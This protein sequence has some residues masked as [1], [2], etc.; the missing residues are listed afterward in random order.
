MASSSTNTFNPDVLKLRLLTFQDPNIIINNE[1]V[2]RS[3]DGFISM[4]SDND[5]IS[6]FL[7]KVNVVDAYS[8][9]AAS[10][11]DVAGYY[12]TITMTMLPSTSALPSS[13][14]FIIGNNGTLQEDIYG[15]I[16]G[17]ITNLINEEY[18]FIVRASLSMY[19]SSTNELVRTDNT[20]MYCYFTSNRGD[21][22]YHWD[23][24]WLSGLLYQPLS[25]ST[26][27]AYSL[28][29]FDRGE[30]VSFTM[31]L[32]NRPSDL[33]MEIVPITSGFVFDD[34]GLKLQTDGSVLGIVTISF[35]PGTYYFKVKGYRTSDST[36]VG[37]PELESTIFSITFT[38]TIV[39]DI[40]Q[41]GFI[42]W[43]TDS[44]LGTQYENYPSFFG[45]SASNP[46][47][48]T[49]VYTV[50]Q[51]SSMQLPSSMVL[52]SSSGLIT[53][54]CPYVNISTLYTITIRA[55]V[56]LSYSEKTFTFTVKPIYYT[57]RVF[58]LELPVT[59]EIRKRIAVISW[60]TKVIDPSYVYRL[61]DENFGRKRNQN[62]YFISGLVDDN[63]FMGYWKNNL[64]STDPSYGVG[65]DAPSDGDYT[66]YSSCFLD[67]LM[68]YHH[69]YD[70]EIN[71]I[72]S[73]P[74]YDPNGNHICDVVYYTI[75]DNRNGIGGFDSNNN[76]QLL[77]DPNKRNNA[78]PEWNMT[79]TDTRIFPASIGNCRLDLI[80]TTNR[81]NS[82]TYMVR[83][84]ATSGIGLAKSEGL[85]M[86]M[87]NSKQTSKNIGFTAAIEICYCSA[88]Y[89]S[90]VVSSINSG[91]QYN[92][93]GEK[94][95]IDRYIVYR[96][97]TDKMH[98]DLNS[99]TG[100]ETTFDSS[101]NSD[102][103]IDKDTGTWFDVT[104]TEYST[105]V[106][107]PPG[108]IG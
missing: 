14:S 63:N 32:D 80:M 21:T 78:I 33:V 61:D 45:V 54:K 11:T 66:N 31:V 65:V 52:N 29:T 53:G 40:G 79:D 107:F 20:D 8:G 2:Q 106:K 59:E 74:V 83:P 46:N 5:I 68:N 98:F 48:D 42:T 88:N 77:I 100:A 67:K 44:N 69:P 97:L 7:F 17:S 1:A 91:A 22:D 70:V 26:S 28:G 6:N 72:S 90:V 35:T 101:V 27:V 3:S 99:T 58:R 103:S 82:P 84:N 15:N 57:D 39:S 18:Q 92:L 81:I 34:T 60:D 105:V 10:L 85:P 95:T 13:L 37:N 24:L 9:E 76:E 62:I 87:L 96:N 47:N 64:P 19:N 16:S 38:S 89:G 55:S 4:L 23:D 49:I 25:N 51:N 71:G 94:F 36:D 73:S 43:N 56:G 93:I 108:D 50:S 102:G 30:V 12:Y 41:T 86:W 104:D 75:T